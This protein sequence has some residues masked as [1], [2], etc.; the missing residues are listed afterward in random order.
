MSLKTVI[1]IDAAAI[2]AATAV[3]FDLATGQVPATLSA[4]GVAA[5][6]EDIAIQKL[7]SDSGGANWT[8]IQEGGT[9][10]VLNADNNSVRIASPG[11]YR[12]LT[13][14]V[15]YASGDVTVVLDY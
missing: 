11:R 8:T 2:A 12:I 7:I 4:N 1:L 6:G 9:G 3:E 15:T 13:A 5:A 10:K 14:N